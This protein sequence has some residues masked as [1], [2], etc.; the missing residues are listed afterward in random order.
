VGEETEEKRLMAENKPFEIPIR[1][2][3]PAGEELLL[4][5]YVAVRKDLCEH[6]ET[7]LRK[8]A[9]LA[10]LIEKINNPDKRKG[11]NVVRLS[12][13]I[14]SIGR[15]LGDDLAGVD[16]LLRPPAKIEAAKD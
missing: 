6:L 4:G 14:Y 3:G 9:Q 12:E 1:F 10:N 13:Q 16:E 11:E 8:A 7:I 2:V 15:E 5:E